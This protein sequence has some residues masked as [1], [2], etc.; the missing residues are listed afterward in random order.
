MARAKA[1]KKDEPVIVTPPSEEDFSKDLGLISP[2]DLYQAA[3][4]AGEIVFDLETTS[5][6]PR[7][8]RIECIGFYVPPTAT[9]P[10][11]RAYYPF[12]E[13]TM[14]VVR[15]NVVRSLRPAMDQTDTMRRLLPI[16]REKRIRK[17]GANIKFDMAW[18]YVNPGIDE[19]IILEG[20]IGDSQ[21]ADYMSD[22]RRRRYGL[23]VRVEEEFGIKMTTYEEA[24]QRQGQLGFMNPKPLGI[25]NMDDCMYTYM[26]HQRALEKIRE[27]DPSG[28]LEKIYWQIEMKVCRIIMEMETTGCLIDW[29]WL[30]ELEKKLESEKA[31][32]VKKIIT[33]AGWAPNLRSPSQVSDFLFNSPEEGG[34]GLPTDGL[35]QNAHGDYSTSEKVIKHFG[36]KNALVKALLDFRSL[37]VIDRSFCKKLIK[38][39]QEEGRVYTGFNQTTTV[40]GRLSSSKPINL[41]NQPRDK[42]LIRK[43]F[44]AKLPGDTSSDLILLDGD[45]SQIELRLAAHT[46]N[47][48][49]LLEVYNSGGKCACDRF[50]YWHE[51]K[52]DRKTKCKWEGLI[53]PDTV[54]LTPE[55]V[56]GPKA[57]PKCGSAVLLQ[58]RCR[59]VDVHQRTAEDVNVPR[60]PL[61]KNLNFGVL[62]R[63]GAPK[64]AIYA[65]LFL[66]DGQPN[67]PYARE[68]IDKWMENYWRIPQ[69]HYEVEEKLKRNNWIAYTL[70][71][72]RRRLDQERNFNEYGAVTQA[73]NFEIQGTAQDIIKLGMIRVYE[74]RARLIANSPPATRKMWERMKFM[75]QVH[76]EC[77]WEIP[78]AIADEA[79]AMV[80]NKMETSANLRCPLVFD[81]K[82]GP[83]WDSVH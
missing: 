83:D 2:E 47:E 1:K 13:N 81:I 29:Q 24:S 49:S 64:F 41:Q 21:L 16:F 78:E 44:V 36:R 45:F 23:K 18:L 3:L 46:A 76:D 9:R 52:D 17:I 61:A 51:C 79:A 82:K 43:A 71:K 4:E 20:E 40:T 22:E 67:I 73:I 80:K 66:E 63:I 65:D 68:V 25:Y 50:L 8:G 28:K 27:Q 34:L 37:E 30:V 11:I 12:V 19:P 59:H 72:R 53:K 77:M 57:C 55:G 75:I 10:A 48:P 39:G 5:L 15:G 26:H 58:K 54:I 62:Y 6:S 33:E 32:I 74:E 31:E 35:E 60:N 38:I 69:W 7:H 42:N 14:V 56:G 70:T